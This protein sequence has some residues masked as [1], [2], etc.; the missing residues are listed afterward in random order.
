[1]KAARWWAPDRVRRAIRILDGSDGGTRCRLHERDPATEPCAIARVADTDPGLRRPHPA[2]SVAAAS[3]VSFD[4]VLSLQNASG[5]QAFLRAVSSPGSA[6][7]HHYLTDAQ[8]ASRVRADSG[9]GRSGRNLASPGRVHH[10]VGPAGPLVRARQRVREERR[11]GVRHDA[12]LLHGERSQGTARQEHADDPIVARQRRLQRG[13]RQPECDGHQP[14]AGAAR[15]VPQSPASSAFWGQ[16]I[17]TKDQG[18]LYAP[19]TA[20]L[21]YDICGYKPAKLRGAYNLAKSVAS[22]NDGSWRDD[23]IVDAYDSPTLLSDAQHY[24]RLEV[25]L[26]GT[27]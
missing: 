22:G 17:D 23:S 26:F 7:F 10:R 6:T 19:Y 5:A 16:K 15:R 25:H 14:G 12:W 8:W 20:P 1:M 4:L 2:G 27:R 13:R 3:P 21:P 18:S 24:F 11:A 9:R